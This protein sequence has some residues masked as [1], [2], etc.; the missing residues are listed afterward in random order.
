MSDQ[1]Q[2]RGLV[3]GIEPPY[4]AVVFT[5]IRREGA[6]GSDGG[7]GETAVLMRELV[8]EIPGYLGYETARNPGG[9]GITVGYFRDEEA[10]AAWRGR[11][12]HQQAQRRGRAEWYE[13]YSVHVA[14]VERSYGFERKQ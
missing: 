8:A 3:S 2:V 12:E 9:I 1:G 13:G 7:Y 11:L 4:Y 10:V 6:D 5:S 14:K